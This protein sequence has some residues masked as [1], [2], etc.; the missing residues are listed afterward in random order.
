[1]RNSCASNGF[2]IARA[3]TNPRMMRIISF[4]SSSL[5]GH[6][7]IARD[8]VVLV[9]RDLDVGSI[10]A[11]ALAQLVHARKVLQHLVAR[12]VGE[13]PGLIGIAVG[14]AP[15]NWRARAF[16][17]GVVHERHPRSG[18]EPAVQVREERIDSPERDMRP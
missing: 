7:A 10:A 17:V 18:G 13:A 16:E 2:A 4:S 6:Y 9:L 3:A 1:M 5:V 15:R 12:P 14:V 8:P 11:H